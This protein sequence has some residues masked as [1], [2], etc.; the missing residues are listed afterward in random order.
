MKSFQE[1]SGLT[2]D[3]GLDLLMDWKPQQVKQKQQKCI[4]EIIL[5][6]LAGIESISKYLIIKSEK[7]SLI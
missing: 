7:G 1:Q 2:Y 4:L 6:F 3:R 5:T